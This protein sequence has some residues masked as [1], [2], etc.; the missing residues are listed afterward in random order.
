MKSIE[1]NKVLDKIEGFEDLGQ[2]GRTSKFA[3][4]ALVIMIRGLYKNWKFPFSYFFTGSG[5]KGDSLVLIVEDCVQKLLNLDLSPTSI[6]CDQGTQNRRMF[7]LFGGTE[8]NPSTVL[9]GKKLFLIYDMPHLIKSIRNNLL[10]GDFKI[11]EKLISLNDVKKTYE[12]D[13]KNSARAML[14]ITPTHL[15]PNPFQKMSCKLAIQILSRSVSSA[16]KTCINTGELKSK[17]ALNTA[18][19]IEIINDMFDFGSSKNLYDTNPNRRPMSDRNLNVVRKL[20]KARSLFINAEKI[21]FKNEKSS[22]PPCF[23]GIIWTTTAICEL[24]EN[25]KNEISK[26]HPNKELF[27]MTNRLTQDALENLFS[28]M[29]QQNGYNKNPTARMFRCCFG[30]ICTYSLM[31]CST[32]C[33]NCEP[34]DDEYMTVDILKDVVVENSESM[35]DDECTHNQKPL[36]DSSEDSD[37]ISSLENGNNIV[38]PSLEACS[39]V[40]LSGY[41]ANKCLE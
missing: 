17:T 28:V 19:L 29:R 6:V 34:D 16:I 41:L 18:H 24:F 15:S 37:S 31:K 26:V 33:N 5:V 21:S 40:Y 27:L 10:T 20:E 39:I 30:H 36:Q 4:H 22:V 7:S 12:I 25:E 2:L 1:Y 23:T 11:N 8:N 38:V 35:Y 14:K 13:I 9:C 32:S 3:S